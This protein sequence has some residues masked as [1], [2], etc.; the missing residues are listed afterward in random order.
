SLSRSGDD[1]GEAAGH[2]D[3]AGCAGDVGAG[4][5]IVSLCCL[6]SSAAVA[7]FAKEIIVP[8]GDHCGLPAPRASVVNC[9]ASPP[10]MGSIKSCGGSGRPSLSGDRTKQMYLPSG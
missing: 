9:Q 3:A 5:G 8:S 4:T 6:A 2:G 10:S 1:R 7:P